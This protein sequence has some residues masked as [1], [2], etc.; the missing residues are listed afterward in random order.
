MADSDG[1]LFVRL[2]DDSHFLLK[3]V[4]IGAGTYAIRCPLTIDKN[5]EDYGQ[6]NRF[7]RVYEGTAG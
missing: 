3:Q 1:F 7:F 4:A 5:K 2:I 6:T